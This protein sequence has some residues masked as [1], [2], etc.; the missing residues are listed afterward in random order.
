MEHSVTRGKQRQLISFD[1]CL[2][3]TLSLNLSWLISA[4]ENKIAFCACDTQLEGFEM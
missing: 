3:E 4:V 1:L 2:I